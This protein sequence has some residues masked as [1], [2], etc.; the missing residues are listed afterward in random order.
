M[1]RFDEMKKEV[2]QAGKL[3]DFY[4]DDPAMDYINEIYGYALQDASAKLDDDI[5]VDVSEN[6]NDDTVVMT[7]ENGQTSWTYDE[8][9]NVLYELMMQANNEKEFK[10]GIMD[11][12]LKKY[13]E[14][15]DCD[16]E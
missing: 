16:D 15:E 10:Q 9:C 4:L 13:D 5:D 14:C 12:V 7:C 6:I 2:K 3:Q 11:F 8:D 1:A